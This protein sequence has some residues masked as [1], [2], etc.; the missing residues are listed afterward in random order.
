MSA[1]VSA[2]RTLTRLGQHD[3]EATQRPLDFRLIMRLLS[4]TRQYGRMRTWLIILVILRSFQLPGLTWVLTV[5]MTGP[6]AEGNVVG[7]VWGA[8][9]F[10][11]LA[12][13]T[14]WVM[15]YRQLYALELGEGVVHDLRNQLFAHLQRMPL[16]FYHRTKVGRVISRMVSD[17]E[18]V[19]VG[20]QEVL[21][22]SLV[23]VGQMLVA[24]VAMLW[25]DR[26][27]FLIVLALA[28]IL[29]ALNHY[30][31]RRLSDQ[32]RAMRE[33]FSRVTA[34]LVESVLGI[35]VTQGFVR[36]DENAR[37]F[38][39]LVADHSR[40]NTQ[41]LHTHGLFIP[42][43]EFNSQLF[44]AILLWVG[45][46][47]ALA[48]GS[49]AGVGDL[50]SFLFMANLFFAPISVL[51]NQYN[52]ALT[53][54]AGAERLF[55]LLDTPPEWSD[56]PDAVAAPPLK[57][58]VEFDGVTFGYDPARPVLR[59]I[60]FRAEPG[61]TIAL[62]GHTGSGKS[63]IINLL[64]KFYLPQQGRILLDGCDLHRLTGDSVHRQMGLVLQQNFLFRGSVADNIRFG[65]PAATDE[66]LIEVC[67]RLDCLDLI[68]ALPRGFD[69]PVGER[70]AQLSLGQR[71][72]ICFARALIADPRILILDEATSSIDSRTEHRLQ[73][74][75]KVLLAGRTSFVVAHRLSTIR[76]ADLVLVLDHGRIVEAGR[77]HELVAAN[78][79][80]AALHARFAQG[81]T[82]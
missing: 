64:T 43:L 33:S 20:V 80:Y 73:R 65:R 46:W 56:P 16:G 71:Q 6:V 8:V 25:Y 9:A 36:H 51:G 57:G 22:V 72:M 26:Q 58:R 52:Q 21:Y 63:S 39:A 66:A 60:T 68:E 59:D 19:R 61:Q 35:R 50:I 74:A 28:P 17:I 15:H 30:F 11:L 14:Q 13:S 48:E 24:A 2:P 37:M 55:D 75:L 7:V 32:L 53:A 69:T 18:D 62:V 27:L 81:M 4:S 42:L 31:R 41:V 78:G 44:I 3:E 45:G 12:L 1:G 47:K 38:A 40:Y 70:G 76:D 82:T 67:R 34:T 5:V 54:M 23:Q 79:P 77:H 49:A 10:A 29:W